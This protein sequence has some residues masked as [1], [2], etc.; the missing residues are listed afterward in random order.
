MVIVGVLAAALLASVS[1]LYRGSS[2]PTA[3]SEIYRQ[4]RQMA[5]FLASNYAGEAVAVSDLG[6][7]AWLHEGHE[8]DLWG[9]ASIEVVRAVRSQQFDPQF[10]ADIADRHDVRAVVIYPE[11]FERNRGG[12]PDEWIAVERWCLDGGP[13]RV[14][15]QGC[16]V[17]Y[18]PTSDDAATLRHHLDA[19]RDLLPDG[20]TVTTL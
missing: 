8:L 13:V 1:Q 3:S 15:G 14:V 19:D 6:Y 4:Q 20:I 9:L 17:W 2:L 10:M 5:R 16:V 7:V 11:S 12:V 18:G